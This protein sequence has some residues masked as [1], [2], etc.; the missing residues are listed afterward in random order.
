VPLDFR[1]HLVSIV[2]FF[3]ALLIGVLVGIAL[4][5]DPD[6]EKQVLAYT[7]LVEEKDARL[8]Q[9]ESRM[10]ASQT[11]GKEL[12]PELIR[13]KLLGRHL[14]II[15]NSDHR[16]DPMVE[17]LT[18]LLVGAGARVNSVT[19]VLLPFV[20]LVSRDAAPIL[21]EAG[22][23]MPVDRNVRA[24]LAG[25][26]ASHIAQGRPELLQRLRARRLIEVQGDYTQPADCIV[27]VGG[28]RNRER[29]A[30]EAIDLP[31]VRA[32]Q[33]IGV[34][35]VACEASDAPIST[36]QYYQS[37]RISTVDDADTIPGQ[38]ALVLAISGVEGDYGV[39]PTADHLLPPRSQW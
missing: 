34:Q 25:K 5:G 14:A 31:M 29:M 21:Q 39:K 6:L 8:Q 13:N 19:T 18:P 2:A 24:L 26:M 10:R 35:V 32:L 23:P 4:V 22:Y 20:N 9:L 27:L 7:A 1:Y 37:R 30:V 33:D 28:Y 16:Q 15:T 12:L 3:G 36:V 17:Q 38:L 11:F